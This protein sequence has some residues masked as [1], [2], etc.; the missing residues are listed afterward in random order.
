MK[1]FRVR[2]LLAYCAAAIFLIAVF[3][4]TGL[5]PANVTG[6]SPAGAAQKGHVNIASGWA[7]FNARG[8]DPA[9]QTGA[10]PYASRT[11]FDS[12]AGVTID[13]M[14]IPAIAKSFKISTGWKYVDFF[15]RTDV[16]FHNGET[17]TAEDVKY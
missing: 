11:V 14:F 15:L 17:V 2:Q 13:R 7:V 9:T 8:G 16:K 6:L 1:S 10:P 12:L 5:S 3:N 4:V